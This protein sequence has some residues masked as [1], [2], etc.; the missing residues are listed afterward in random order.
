M[1]VC[2]LL[3]GQASIQGKAFCAMVWTDKEMFFIDCGVQSKT[4]RKKK[5][6]SQTISFDFIT[7]IAKEFS[8]L[9]P[10]CVYCTH[11]HLDHM[12]KGIPKN[13]VVLPGLT[14][15]WHGDGWDLM[16]I[17]VRH[18][19]GVDTYAYVIETPNGRSVFC[20]EGRPPDSIYFHS[21]NFMFLEANYSPT[22]LQLFPDTEEY[23]PHKRR[24]LFH[25]DNISAALFAKACQPKQLVIGNLSETFNT[26]ALALLDI[27]Q[28][29]GYHAELSTKT[30]AYSHKPFV[31]TI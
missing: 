28:N 7:K 15:D 1:K 31:W 29:S 18:D 13:M 2:F 19:T 27:E 20:V 24:S 23:Y 17:K 21:A 22:I 9:Y 8:G 5:D 16:S 30:V 12:G 11:S 4:S 25:M 10:S 6:G 3:H 14:Q 26:P